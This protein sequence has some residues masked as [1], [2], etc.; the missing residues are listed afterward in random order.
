M[1]T[2]CPWSDP[3]V[4]ASSTLVTPAAPAATVAA[5]ATTATTATATTTTTTT[6][7]PDATTSLASKHQSRNNVDSGTAVA[8]L[9]PV[10]N[11]D[12]LSA[13]NA[14]LDS[15]AVSLVNLAWPPQ[16]APSQV[17][18]SPINPFLADSL[19]GARQLPWAPTSLT[20]DVSAATLPLS[21]SL[22][23]SAHSNSLSSAQSTSP[24]AVF[25]SCGSASAQG[26]GSTFSS[27]TTSP[28]TS[29]N[30]SSVSPTSLPGER[31]SRKRPRKR[32]MAGRPSTKRAS[33]GPDNAYNDNLS[34]ST[35]DSSQN[36]GKMKLPRLDRGQED[37]SSVV[38]NR[39]Q[40]YTRTGQACDRCK[41]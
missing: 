5:T 37:F 7:S 3:I 16:Q 33:D 32:T 14:I 4:D 18:D 21:A 23:L 41:V 31:R 39:L 34:H 20:L 35:S 25:S 2:A 19:S 26:F 17:A 15:T 12:A 38:K 1:Y 22:P 40:S 28:P 24:L 6:T 36:G 29:S 27:A 8:L 9:N 30:E 11:V 13:P 10:A